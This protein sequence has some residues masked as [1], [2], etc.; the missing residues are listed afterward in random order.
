MRLCTRCA[1]AAAVQ[2]WS[3]LDCRQ[4]SERGS[5]RCVNTVSNI[6][7]EDSN[8]DRVQW[9]IL[10]RQQHHSK[11]TNCILFCLE[12]ESDL[13]CESPENTMPTDT[14]FLCEA[15]VLSPRASPR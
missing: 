7:Q 11:H 4:Y 15:S 6:R 8:L 5:P 13:Y 9:C 10:F 3:Q 2:T 12:Y 14:G 1:N